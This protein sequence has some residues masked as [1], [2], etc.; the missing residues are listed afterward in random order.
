MARI[1]GG[2]PDGTRQTTTPP[3][4]RV[5]RVFTLLAAPCGLR[6]PAVV[7][8]NLRALDEVMAVGM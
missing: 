1:P 4:G 6:L 2:A 7:T 8:E 3:A 5:A